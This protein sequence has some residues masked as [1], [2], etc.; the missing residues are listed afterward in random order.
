MFG[1]TERLGTDNVTVAGLGLRLDQK[2]FGF[3]TYSSPP[4]SRLSLSR[5]RFSSVYG[6][7][8]FARHTFFGGSSTMLARRVLGRLTAVDDRHHIGL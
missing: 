7:F 5:R 2:H 8:F 3:R 4:D 1:C 6:V